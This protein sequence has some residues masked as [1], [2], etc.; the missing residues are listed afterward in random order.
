MNTQPATISPAQAPPPGAFP[1]SNLREIPLNGKVV[2]PRLRDNIP[3]ELRQL[4]N[5]VVRASSS[6]T[7]KIPFNPISGRAAEAND[8]S[9]WASFDE[10]TAAI[11]KLR[12]RDSVADGVGCE[13]TPPYTG[14]DIDDC[15]IEGKLTVQAEK[16][17]IELDSYAE[18]SP[19]GTGVHIWARGRLPSGHNKKTF[20]D[21]KSAGMK[22]IELYDHDR[23]LTV[24]GKS[25]GYKS[26]IED[27]QPQIDALFKSLW[28][29]EDEA[30]GPGCTNEN[31]GFEGTDEELLEAIR[32]SAQA[33]KFNALMAGDT[34][35]YHS[36]DSSADMGL[37]CIFAWWTGNGAERMERLFGLSKLA[38]REKWRERPDYRARP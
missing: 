24:T 4:P 36:D 23:Y 27:R 21:P 33:P 34:S 15:V 28:P 12:L 14:V 2:S 18:F 38:D 26:T 5:W 29:P 37:L 11:G 13:I 1:Q 20:S 10:A 30:P 3:L 7:P 6:K 32:R 22:A 31:F 9:T 8:P 19:S 35:Q 16:I 17:I 25:L